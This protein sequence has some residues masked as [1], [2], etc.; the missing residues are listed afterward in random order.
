MPRY[1]NSFPCSGKYIMREEK[2]KN[3]RMLARIPIPQAAQESPSTEINKNK[4]ERKDFEVDISF[5]FCQSI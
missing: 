4:N 3:E 1:A 5:V 2:P